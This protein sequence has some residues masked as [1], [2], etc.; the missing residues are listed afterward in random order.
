MLQQRGTIASVLGRHRHTDAGGSVDDS[1]R[2][3]DITVQLVEHMRHDALERHTR[4][5]V[6]DHDHELIAAEPRHDIGLTHAGA[7]PARHLGQQLVADVMTERVVHMLEAIQVD[8]H[9]SATRIGLV[10]SG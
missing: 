8:Q 4:I 6:R 7:H 2:Q 3:I 5:E 10:S 9:H 1:P